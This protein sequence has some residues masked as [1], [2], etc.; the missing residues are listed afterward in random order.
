[1][2]GSPSR[3]SFANVSIFYNLSLVKTFREQTRALI[4]TKISENILDI[5]KL[6]EME[7]IIKLRDINCENNWIL[8]LNQKLKLHETN[9]FLLLIDSDAFIGFHLELAPVVKSYLLIRRH[10]EF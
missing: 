4:P 5:W 3:K 10:G 9:E 7:F 8:S 6:R 2:D 1:M